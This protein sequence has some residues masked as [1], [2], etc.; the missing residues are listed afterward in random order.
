VTGLLAEAN[1]LYLSSN[2]FLE[3]RR[4]SDGA[5]LWSVLAGSTSD[6]N[7]AGPVL[8]QG[9]LYTSNQDRLF[10]VR[11]SDG[12]VLWQ[13][14][15]QP[16][17]TPGISSF[18]SY[19]PFVV[20]AGIVFVGWTNGLVTAVQES[21]G[22]VLWQT[23]V[24]GVTDAPSPIAEASGQVYI[25]AG[26]GVQILSASDGHLEGT[27]PGLSTGL[28]SPATVTGGV[29]Y[30]TSG[31]LAYA[32]QV[33]ENTVLWQKPLQSALAA[34]TVVQ[35]LV[36]FPGAAMLLRTTDGSPLQTTSPLIALGPSGGYQAMGAI[37]YVD[38]PNA[39]QPATISAFHEPD[40]ELLWRTILPTG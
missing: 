37:R 4:A 40:Q 36:F 11:A 15:P 35:G 9:I 1:T 23:A 30:T 28:F 19:S 38:N 7:R 13:V 22:T 32:V 14:A 10:A 24:G 33:P 20:N 34:P 16:T 6:G 3:A 26:Q 18:E 27:L 5:L 25:S 17:N 29:L 31:E 21:S 2:F 8:D 39:D 12:H